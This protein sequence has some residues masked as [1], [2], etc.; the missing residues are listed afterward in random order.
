[1]QM[2]VSTTGAQ[3][4]VPVNRPRPS[5]SGQA[6]L[7]AMVADS[8]MRVTGT[9]LHEGVSNSSFSKK[10]YHRLGARTDLQLL[11]DVV[12]VFAHGFNVHA[13]NVGNFLVGQAFGKQFQHFALAGREWLLSAGTGR[14]VMK[15]L[16]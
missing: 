2:S 9:V 6:S 7:R 15:I 10:L 5:Q 4:S 8:V 1:M 3:C 14:L 16:D 12:A 13:E 11:V